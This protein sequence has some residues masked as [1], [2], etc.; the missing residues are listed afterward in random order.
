ML[1]TEAVISLSKWIHEWKKTYGEKP[2]LDE[3]ITWVEWKFSNCAI[4]QKDKNSIEVI[5]ESNI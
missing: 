3:C 4:S 1:T 5:L 2:S